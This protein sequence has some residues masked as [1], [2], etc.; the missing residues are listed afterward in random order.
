MRQGQKKLERD[1][2]IGTLIQRSK[3]YRVMRKVLFNHNQRF[4]MKF[5]KQDVLHSEEEKSECSSNPE[6][7]DLF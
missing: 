5:Q 7:Q 3:D 2:D 1:L 6:M 4:M